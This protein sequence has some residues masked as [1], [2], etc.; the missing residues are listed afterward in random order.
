[1]QKVKRD[2]YRREKSYADLAGDL[3]QEGI[4][5]FATNVWR[6]LKSAGFKTTKLTRKPGLTQR[7]REERLKWCKDHK[8]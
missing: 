5:I 1:M 7:M 4:R 2:C 8:D 6:I 3:S